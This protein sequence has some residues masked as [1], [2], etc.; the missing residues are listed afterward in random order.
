VGAWTDGLPT[1]AWGVSLGAGGTAIW[2]EGEVCDQ[3]LDELPRWF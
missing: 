1:C 3:P 2:G